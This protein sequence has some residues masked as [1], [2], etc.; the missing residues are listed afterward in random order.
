MDNKIV[1]P[2]EKVKGKILYK[3]G[4]DFEFPSFADKF[5]F[6]STRTKD[7]DKIIIREG[8]VEKIKGYKIINKMTTPNGGVFKVVKEYK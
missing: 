3:T 7:F 5:W 2:F 1:V 8:N 4:S 6:Y